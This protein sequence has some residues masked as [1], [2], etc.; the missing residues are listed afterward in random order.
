[1]GREQLITENSGFNRGVVANLTAHQFKPGQSGNPGG[2]PKKLPI[3]DYLTEQL[4]MQ[5]PVEMKERV[6]QAFRRLYGEEA[7]FGELLAFQVIAKAAEGDMKAM[8]AVLERVEGRVS[9]SVAVSGSEEVFRTI[10]LDL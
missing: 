1:M 7:T 8:N 9:Q 2:R 4:A 10:V 3:T 5:I 6:P